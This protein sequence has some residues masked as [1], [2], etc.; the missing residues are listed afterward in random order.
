MVG[1]LQATG[2]RPTFLHKFEKRGVQLPMGL[3]REQQNRNVTELP[4]LQA[5]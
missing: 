2:L 1:E 4:G 5:R 3:F